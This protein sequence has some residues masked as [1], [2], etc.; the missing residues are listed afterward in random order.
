MKT[1]KTLLLT[2]LIIASALAIEPIK[3]EAGWSGFIILGGGYLKYENNEV[4]GNR[5]VDVEDKQIDNLGSPDSQTT[6]IPVVT[7][8][9]RYTLDNKK[10][11]FFLGNSLEDYL[12][13]DATLALGVRH[14]FENIG[15]LGIRLL[16][17]VTPTDVW[18]D[19]FHRGSDRSD[20]E[21]TSAGIGL[22]WERI[23]DTKFEIDFRGRNIE[24]DRD[25][26][27]ESLNAERDPGLGTVGDLIGDNGAHYIDN[28]GQKLLEREGTHA[29]LELLYTWKMND[30]NR[31]IPAVKFMNDDRDGE[32]RD[33]T[34]TELKL[35]HIYTN[36]KWLVATSLYAGASSY[37][38]ENPVFE[39]KQDTDYLGGGMN[40]TRK[41]IFGWKDWGLN[42]GFF[43][44]QGDSDIDFYD[45]SMFI[46]TLGV[47]YRF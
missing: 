8:I 40:I 47:V 26:N 34:R 4:A 45:T 44:S 5:L 6:G 15:I 10:T 16:A 19:P 33:N 9:V 25:R 11:E 32:A 37:D 2:S 43:A 39:K 35:S 41:D 36:K 24:F 27:G 42:G 18:E 14:D 28:S 46:A 1:V 38:K 20:T 22:K 3:K 7:G 31:L 29:S 23:M 30:D 13:M 21:R 17:S 12:R